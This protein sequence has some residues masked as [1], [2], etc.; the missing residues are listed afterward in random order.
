MSA[1]S[2]EK[3]QENMSLKH[4]FAWR[5]IAIYRS[6]QQALLCELQLILTLLPVATTY[7]FNESTGVSELMSNVMSLIN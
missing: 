1:L 2:L 6:L 4:F 7:L 3:Q 5:D